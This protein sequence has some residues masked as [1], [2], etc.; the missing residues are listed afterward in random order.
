MTAGNRVSGKARVSGGNRKHAQVRCR[1]HRLASGVIG[2]CLVMVF[3]AFVFVIL[4]SPA[5]ASSS[6]QSSRLLAAGTGAGPEVVPGTYLTLQCTHGTIS[7]GGKQYC[8]HTTTAPIDLCDSSSCQFSMTGTVDSG[9]TFY[10]WVVSM[11]ASV[12]CGSC[13]NTTLT[14]YTPNPG[15]RY[16]ASVTLDTTSPPPPP[17]PSEV[18]ITVATFENGSTS[19]LPAQVQACLNASCSETGNG[20]ILTLYQYKAYT[21]SL[22]YIQQNVSFSQWATDAGSLASNSSTPTQFTPTESGTLTLVTKWNPSGWIGYSDS[23]CAPSCTSVSGVF[24]LPLSGGIAGIGMW[25][26]I[27]GLPLTGGT[28]TNL[29]QAGV[30]MNISGTNS[31]AIHAFWV[32]CSGPTICSGPTHYNYAFPINPGDRIFVWVESGWGPSWFEIRDLSQPG[33]PTWS[34]TDSSFSASTQNVEWVDEPLQKGTF[35]NISVYDLR[36]LGAPTTMYDDSMA[37]EWSWRNWVITPLEMGDLEP[38]S[39]TTQFVIEPP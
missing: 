30:Q 10:G 14:L 22:V 4:P 33:N 18:W 25:V 37:L 35:S 27:G 11:E 38:G 20:G 13:L 32:A 36:I 8:S 15:N 24:T 7:L 16:S 23:S 31:S 5:L 2:L 19:W 12:G 1:A 29:W 39:F 9:Y 21:I 3:A 34:L 28:Y 17:P 6:T 26:G